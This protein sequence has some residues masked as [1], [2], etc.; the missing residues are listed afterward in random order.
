MPLGVHSFYLDSRFCP[1]AILAAL[2]LE[3]VA[4][5]PPTYSDQGV[6][7][8]LVSLKSFTDRFDNPNP[9]LLG[10]M[11]ASYDVSCLFSQVS[12]RLTFKYLWP[13]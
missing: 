4:D 12:L 11:V 3:E 2:F 1:K 9:A 7:G 6:M 13:R 5:K 10:F 8:G